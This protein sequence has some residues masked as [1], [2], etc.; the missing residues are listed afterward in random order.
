[1]T[2]RILVTGASGTTGRP[3]V[4]ALL[5][6]GSAV[7][8]ATRGEEPV[9]P[10]AEHRRFD[11]M[12]PGTYDAVLEGVERAYVL[13][14]GLVADPSEIVLSFLRRG[15]A[16]G[17]R[18]VVLLSSSAIEEGQAGL[19]RIHGF[20]RAR[21]PQWTVLQPSWFMQNL[22]DTRTHHHRSLVEEGR[23]V[24]A[25]GEGRVG[26]VDARDIA[27]VG[28]CALADSASPDAGLRITGPR[29]LTYAEVAAIVGEI[30][31]D[32]VRHEHVDRQ[33]VIEHMMEASIPRSYAS[34][35]AD[36]EERI[37]RGEE[38]EVTDVVERVTGRA[39][40]SLEAFAREHAEALRRQSDQ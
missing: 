6:R 8:T 4:E 18:R 10:R 9:D 40:R 5:A 32:D 12:D 26:F 29:A 13:A 33:G 23:L 34:L 38:G 15:L 2:G 25:T 20:L 31:G 7:R 22:V 14:P 24:T 35:L 27:A 11:W 30:T 1:M 21:V 16:L 36:L 39:P 37:R 17:L 3:I 19:G 28:A